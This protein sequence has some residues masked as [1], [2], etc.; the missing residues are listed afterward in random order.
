L[1]LA[2]YGTVRWQTSPS[3]EEIPL[4][5]RIV[6]VSDVFDALTSRRPYKEPWPMTKALALLQEESGHQFDPA[7][8]EAF[9]QLHD[10]GV[11]AEI[12]KRFNTCSTSDEESQA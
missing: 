12:T 6:K 3:G 4:S 2:K 5:A 11:I 8:V 1:V 7:V 10:Q 9:V